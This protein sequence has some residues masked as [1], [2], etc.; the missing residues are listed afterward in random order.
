MS[1]E[2]FYLGPLNVDASSAM[3]TIAG[4]V[5]IDFSGNATANVD[6]TLS[7]FRTLFQYQSDSTEIDN[8]VA[9]DVK[10]R[11]VYAD[12]PSAPLGM[13]IDESAEVVDGAIDGTA[14]NKNVT[15][16]YTRYLALK[17]FNTHLGVD[18]FNNEQELRG[19]LNT[20]FKTRFNALLLALAARGATDQNDNSVGGTHYDTTSPSRIIFNQLIANKP[21]R[22]S[23]ISSNEAEVVDGEHWYYMPGEIGDKFFF[24]INVAAAEDQHD[25]TGVTTPIP[26]RAYLISATIVA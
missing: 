12:A 15:Y 11:V 22:F 21:V 20:S 7:T 10:F 14:G 19:D 6:I 18:L 26:V 17:L 13:D 8:V 3:A 25:L 16:D 9:N 24:L 2:L 1:G 23:D 4:S 5:S